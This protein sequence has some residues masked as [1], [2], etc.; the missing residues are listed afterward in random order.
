MQ[1]AGLISN[2]DMPVHMCTYHTVFSE[3]SHAFELYIPFTVMFY[4]H[5]VK[6]SEYRTVL[7]NLFGLWPLKMKQ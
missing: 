7:T 1:S 5:F 3:L 2:S 4:L 6:K